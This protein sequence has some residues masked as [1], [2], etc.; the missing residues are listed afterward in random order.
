MASTILDEIA[1]NGQVSLNSGNDD[2]RLKA[3][4][5]ASS[6]IQELENSGQQMAR[7]GWREPPRTAALRTAFELREAG[8]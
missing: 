6:L 3:I 5:A 7:I 4:A 1:T 2:A 8:T